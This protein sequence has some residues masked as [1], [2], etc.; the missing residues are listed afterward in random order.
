MERIRCRKRGRGCNLQR[1]VCSKSGE[2]GLPL[3]L[4]FVPSSA[5]SSPFLL[6]ELLC[7]VKVRIFVS[8]AMVD[9]AAAAA[10]G[11]RD[12]GGVDE[13]VGVCKA[14]TGAAFRFLDGPAAEEAEVWPGVDSLAL[15]DGAL[16]LTATNDGAPC[17]D[18]EAPEGG[19][20]LV[21]FLVVVV[22][23]DVNS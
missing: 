4:S 14:A 23:A 2:D 18:S 17:F 8:R 11:L 12:G 3:M 21:L 5:T 6:R 22:A 19:T 15:A 10:V 7:L 16:L 13:A 1:W 9:D 20:S